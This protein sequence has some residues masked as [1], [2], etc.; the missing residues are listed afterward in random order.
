MVDLGP[1][2]SAGTVATACDYRRFI[3][4]GLDA[5][6]DGLFRRGLVTWTSGANAGL[7]MEVK[8]HTN[9]GGVVT[10]ELSLPMPD[11]IA[12]GDGFSIQAGCDKTWETCRQRFGN[13]DNFGGFPHMPGP[14]VVIGYANQDDRNDAGSLFR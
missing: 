4:S 1:W 7:A 12:A 6:K 10:I 11:A 9:I 2:T 5:F 3:A 13:G 8:T 14:E